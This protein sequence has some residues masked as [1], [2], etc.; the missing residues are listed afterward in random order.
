MGTELIFE[1]DW[2]QDGTWVEEAGR[3][4]ALRGRIGFAAPGQQVADVGRMTLELDNFDGRYDAGNAAGPLYGKLL[5]RRAAQVRA[6]ADGGQWWVIF[7]GWIERIEVGAGT[8]RA[9]ITLVD[10]L[11][12]LR[13]EALRVSYAPSR[14][15]VECL[16]A[17]VEQAYAAPWPDY[18]GEGEVLEHVGWRWLPERMT[19][20]D[21]V[22]DVVRTWHGRFW[23]SR[24]GDPTYRG[25]AWLQKASGTETLSLGAGGSAERDF[26]DALDTAL[27]V[28]RVINAA[29][30]VTYPVDTLAAESVLWSASGVLRIAPGETRTLWA[31][32]R[33]ERGVRCAAVDVVTPVPFT[34]FRVTEF[35][36]G[37]GVDYTTGSA[38]SLSMALEATRA[39]L[40]LRN[41][42]TG[43]LYAQV[44]RIRGKPV[45]EHAPVIGQAADAASQ[46]TYQKRAV[47]FDLPMQADAA[48]GQGL[49][50]YTV[51][52]YSA[53]VVAARRVEFE[54]R[55]M[56]AGVNL[57]GLELMDPISITDPGS[58]LA[59]ARHR[60]SAIE[61]EAGAAGRR[62][63]LEL[64]RCDD[65]TYWRLG[66]PS[67]SELGSQ[68][69]L[70]F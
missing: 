38:F 57:Y 64:E 3:L 50:E 9:T 44:L 1:V 14:D 48:F 5:P 67:Y 59:G 30:V 28:A 51:R 69:R 37:S 41:T 2:S 25:R 35:R 21:G 60:I 7:T 16:G 47:V 26:P 18:Q 66:R 55:E 27:D 45:I 54:D 43:A 23:V 65:R 10:A 29:Q 19:V 58:G 15:A 36:D 22:L 13:G 68:T 6:R 40:T 39:Q 63:A 17:L 49:A 70:G 31:P 46:A 56:V 62:V 4:I 24:W 8:G 20:W 12:L 32:F 52:R 53:P 34:D 61:Y 42:A 11:A 33:D